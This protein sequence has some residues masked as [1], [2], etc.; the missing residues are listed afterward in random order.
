MPRF[1]FNVY[2]GIEI[3]D[4]LGVEL[5]SIT[6]ARREAIRYAGG[7]LEDGARKDSL[8]SE[9]RMEITDESGLVLFRLDFL[10]TDAP[11]LSGADDAVKKAIKSQP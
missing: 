6:Y 5:P 2:D 7:L 9:W 11:V 3:L 8:G 10:V 1:H 4:K